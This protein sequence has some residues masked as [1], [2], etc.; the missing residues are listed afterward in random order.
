MEFCAIVDEAGG[1]KAFQ[2]WRSKVKVCPYVSPKGERVQITEGVI[3]TKRQSMLWRD[4]AF[5]A[6]PLFWQLDKTHVAE[7]E[8]DKV[9]QELLAN[10][11]LDGLME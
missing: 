10:F 7:A 2:E 3:W 9:L 5:K 1:Q 4:F 11:V 8:V 6:L